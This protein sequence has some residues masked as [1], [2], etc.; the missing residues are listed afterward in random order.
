MY[1]FLD[2]RIAALDDGARFEE[3]SEDVAAPLEP[4]DVALESGEFSWPEGLYG[5]IPPSALPLPD[6][7]ALNHDGQTRGTE[8]LIGKPTVMWF[9]PF[10]GT[11]G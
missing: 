10:A 3:R 5:S 2:E 8:D 9:F 1:R 11:P 4:E 7:V 6:F